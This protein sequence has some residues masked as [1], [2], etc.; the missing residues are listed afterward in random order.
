MPNHHSTDPWTRVTSLHGIPA[1]EL[2][3]VLQKSI[4]RGLLENALLAA[5]EMY[6]TSAELE[7]QLWLRLCVISCEDTG[8]GSYFEPVFL[9]SLYQ[10]HQRLDRSYGDRWLFAVHAVR[11]LVERPKD[12]TTDELANLTLHKLN[13]GQLPEIPDWALDVHTRRG[14]EMGRTVEDFWNIHSHVENERPDRDK[15]YLE[16]IKALFTT[17]E[18]KA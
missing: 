13:S 10:M 11:F 6:V 18:W 3:A 14:Q 2:I 9:N 5:R 17:G 7:E 1:D 15:K 8:D 16:Q 12:R 4:R